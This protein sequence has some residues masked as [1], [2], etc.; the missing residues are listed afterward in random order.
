MSLVKFARS[1]RT[2]P[3]G[4][5]G[6][7]GVPRVSLDGIGITGTGAQAED[8]G[9][10]MDKSYVIERLVLEDTIVNQFVRLMVSA[11]IAK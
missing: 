10:A 9:I 1:P 8:P 3:P 7:P 5:T 2:D 4:G 11:G 6:F